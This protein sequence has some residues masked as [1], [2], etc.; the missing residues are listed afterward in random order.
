M[1]KKQRHG[2]STGDAD[3]AT[4]MRTEMRNALSQKLG[5]PLPTKAEVCSLRAG[6]WL[7]IW[8]YDA[9]SQ[10]VLLLDRPRSQKGDVEL[11][12]WNPRGAGFP[13]PGLSTPLHY[14]VCRILDQIELP[15]VPQHG[16][17]IESVSTA[18]AN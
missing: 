7:E 10:V 13:R 12:C 3:I 4:S 9:P 8:W 15:T 16:T 6:T 14:Q 2:V 11:Y 17:S 1:D 18:I 5:V